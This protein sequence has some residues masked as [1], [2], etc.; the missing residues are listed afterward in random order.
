MTLPV[1]DAGAATHPSGL[2]RASA[3][4]RTGAPA[5]SVLFGTSAS[6]AAGSV[7]TSAVTTTSVAASVFVSSNVELAATVVPS[8]SSFSTATVSSIHSESPHA[9]VQ[10]MEIV[11]EAFVEIEHDARNIVRLVR[12]HNDPAYP[13]WFRACAE[14]S[15]QKVEGDQNW[16][17]VYR[18][19]LLKIYGKKDNRQI[20]V[21]KP[22]KASLKILS[23]IIQQLNNQGNG[24]QTVYLVEEDEKLDQ[25][26]SS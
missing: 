3:A 5:A 6:L 24:F 18:R 9:G 12:F 17:D 20:A 21:I 25:E 10:G 1:S 13:L 26:S 23:S 19:V 11:D 22:P 8:A 4:V 14:F 7:S 2:A 16:A 15:I